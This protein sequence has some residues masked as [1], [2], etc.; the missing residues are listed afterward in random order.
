MKNRYQTPLFLSEITEF[1]TKN[2]IQTVVD[3]TFGE[4]GHGIALA[5]H[6]LTVFGFEWD[7]EMYAHAIDLIKNEGVERSV[8]LFNE[9]FAH[10]QSVLKQSG[11]QK[12]NAV[13]FDLGLSMRQLRTSAR[14]F[15]FEGNEPLDLRLNTDESL[16]AAKLIRRSSENELKDLFQKYIEDSLSGA[17]AKKVI[18]ARFNRRI[19]TVGDVREIV[20]TLI[21]TEHGQ[22]LFMRKVL[23]GLRMIVNSE[24]E[25]VE[26]GLV[27][28]ANLLV[29]E[30]VIIIITFHSLEDRVVKLFFKKREGEW[31][32][33]LKK[34]LS[35][36]RSTFARSAKLR[37]YKKI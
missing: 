25:V 10:M 3:A 35:N 8:T 17:F 24:M 7:K 6:G 4:G 13:I 28:A 14:G 18:G 33:I 21:G 34:P 16:T 9:N 2:N 11:V 1:C 31:V 15:T 27:N 29:N 20:N 37:L 30:G 5:K 23:Q 36:V 22:E 19:E 32:S 12:V 26:Q